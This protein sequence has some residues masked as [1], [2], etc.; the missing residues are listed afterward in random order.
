MEEN[1][2]VENQEQEE[3]IGSLDLSQLS[4][5]DLEQYDNFEEFV[6]SQNTT[7]PE[8]NTGSEEPTDSET[9]TQDNE[10]STEEVAQMSDEEFRQFI[11]GEFRANHKTHKVEDPNDIRKLMQYG[12]NFHK[13]MAELAPRRKMLKALEQNGL[14]DESQVNFMI[15]VMKG[16]PEAIAQL[17]RQ[18]E[19]DTYNLPD[20]EE[21]PY[22]SENYLPSDQKVAFDE[23]IDEIRTTPHGNRVVEYLRGL[24]T[25][26][27]HD[28]YT[29]PV[30]AQTLTIHAENGLMED[31]LAMLETEKALGKVPQ[32]IKDIDAYAHIAQ[33]LEKQSPEK[34]YPNRA[35]QRVVGTNKGK[36]SRPVQTNQ[37]KLKAS[38]PN[39]TNMV[40]QQS[41]S[42]LDQL[43]N[44]SSADLAQYNNWE[45]FLA[46]N[47]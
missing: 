36:Q 3:N 41:F 18:H 29:N 14:T 47:S 10:P 15:E 23:V 11:T 19:V 30:M 8:E 27:F 32:G 40:Q 39:N 5:E 34:Y 4:T 42:G 2:V 38:I 1:E 44:A 9:V 25:D 28:V 22:Q 13:K 20:L 31:A 12:M 7:E 17:L 33:Y 37:N 24:D 16:K 21:T 26:S 43:I 45:E 35:N 46:A 6:Q